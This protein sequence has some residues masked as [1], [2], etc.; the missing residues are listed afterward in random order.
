MASVFE[1]IVKPK[2][3][4]RF[5]I[6]DIHGC[7]KTFN[8]LIWKK[9]KLK[10]NDQLFL[11]GDFVD[12]GPDSKGVLDTILKLI[13]KEYLV[14]PL[15]GNHENTLLQYNSEDFRFFHWHLKKN[16]ELNLIKG[17]KLKKKY[18][19]FLKDLPY[20]YILNNFYLVHA[21]FDTKAANLFGDKIAMTEIRNMSYNPKLFD[22][23]KIIFGHHA[24]ALPKIKKSIKENSPLICL[25]NGAVYKDKQK[26]YM[27]TSEMGNL[28]ALDLDTYKLYIQANVD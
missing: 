13:K 19:N 17:Q 4:R 6:G 23:K 26:K 15:R 28:I 24:L 27:D 2:K 9:I 5:V 10:L 22:S 21:G 12:K 18:K 20:Y 14:Y 1:Y 8:K 25:D 7:N 3:G 11:L 16:N